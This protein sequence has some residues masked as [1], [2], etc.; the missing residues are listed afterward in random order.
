MLILSLPALAEVNDENQ[1]ELESWQAQLVAEQEAQE[2]QAA[3]SALILDLMNE[4]QHLAGRTFDES[5]ARRMQDYFNRLSMEELQQAQ[6]LQQAGESLPEASI[7]D[8]NRDLVFT[9]LDTPCRFYDSRN[10][11]AG[12]LTTGG[13]ARSIRV[14]GGAIPPSQGAANFC[15]VLDSAVA[16]VVNVLAVDPLSKGNFQMWPS[17]GG[18]GDSV[19]NY[20]GPSLGINLINGVMVPICN[21]FTSVCPSDLMIRTNFA[22]SH[23]V[24]NVTGFFSPPEPSPFECQNVE[25]SRSV[26]DTTFNFASPSCPSGYSMTGGGHNWT[27][28]TQDVWFWEVSPESNRYR[29]RGRNFNATASEITCYARCCRIPGRNGGVVL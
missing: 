3:K 26:A 22:N 24:I 4:R 1:P 27:T 16:V 23:A 29:C 6:E 18:P 25:A 13:G 15:A 17:D 21:R 11:G 10:T 9:P 5:W 14:A 2:L 7:G 28:H 12:R 20:G 8:V 19:I